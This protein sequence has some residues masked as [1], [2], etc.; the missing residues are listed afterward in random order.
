MCV[1]VCVCVFAYMHTHHVWQCV[2]LWGT[3]S[4][5]PQGL[6]AREA[7]HGSLT[8]IIPH[9]RLGLYGSQEPLDAMEEL[10]TE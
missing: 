3:T 10:R 8:K 5:L 6:A 2:G 4:A 1:C 9:C 7:G